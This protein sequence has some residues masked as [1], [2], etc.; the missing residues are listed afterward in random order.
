[1]SDNCSFVGFCVIEVSGR[2]DRLSSLLEATVDSDE[3]EFSKVTLLGLPVRG[4]KR[5]LPSPMLSRKLYP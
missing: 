2:V 3:F 1:M 4:R 5:E